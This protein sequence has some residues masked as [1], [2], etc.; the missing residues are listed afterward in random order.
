[1]EKRQNVS[2]SRITP[3]ASQAFELTW[4]DIASAFLSGMCVWARAVKNKATLNI[5][6]P[7]ANEDLTC[8]VK[9]RLIKKPE[10]SNCARKIHSDTR[11]R[12]AT[13]SLSTS[14]PQL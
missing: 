6:I 2:N 11:C 8:Y 13:G 7:N 9:A 4:D 12:V 3:Q 5:R 14:L 1:L 10:L